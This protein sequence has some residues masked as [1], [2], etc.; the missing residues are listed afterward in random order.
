MASPRS[1]YNYSS[2]DE[3]TLTLR[4]QRA[5][6]ANVDLMVANVGRIANSVD[7]PPPPSRRG[8][9]V[10]TSDFPENFWDDTLT[11]LTL[12]MDAIGT[13]G[14]SMSA[15]LTPGVGVGATDLS[16]PSTSGASRA[17]R[18]PGVGMGASALA[19]HTTSVGKEP[20]PIN[21]SSPWRRRREIRRR[22]REVRRRTRTT[23]ASR[24]TVGNASRRPGGGGGGC[25]GG[26]GGGGRGHRNLHDDLDRLL[27]RLRQRMGVDVSRAPPTQI[28]H[29]NL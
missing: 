25:G 18:R 2:E 21:V 7:A 16:R 29:H 13:A 3:D 22:A 14:P 11:S 6:A 12:R 15:S 17:S 24:G 9:I 26:G 20:R 10:D 5:R 19:S 8:R 27:D 4:R 28:P 1:P 23:T